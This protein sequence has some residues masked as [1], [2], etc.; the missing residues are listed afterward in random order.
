MYLYQTLKETNKSLT[1]S[2]PRYTLKRKRI[3]IYQVLRADK[4]HEIAK[5]EIVYGCVCEREREKAHE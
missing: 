3:Q 1:K 2:D 4:S 5:A